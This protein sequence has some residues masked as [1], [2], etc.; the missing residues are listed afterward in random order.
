MILRPLWAVILATVLFT[1]TADSRTTTPY[2]ATV[3]HVIDGDTVQVTVDAWEGTPFSPISVR[4]YGIDT[5]EK[6]RN[7]AKCDGEIEKGIAAT[8]FA[9]TL[10]KAGD[11]VTINYLK[12]DKYGGRIVANIILKDGRD[13]TETMITAGHA[14]PY[15]GKKKSS[16]C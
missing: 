6:N 9:Q 5:P 2:K 15:F 10:T 4:V 11:R 13:W 8:R 16:W 1:T 7:R 3:V 14:R 12:L